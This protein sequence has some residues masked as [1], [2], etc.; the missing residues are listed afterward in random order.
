MSRGK[1][2]GAER[3]VR[4]LWKAVGWWTM[5]ILRGWVIAV[6]AIVRTDVGRRA[7]ALRLT[8]SDR[9]SGVVVD[10]A[11]CL[12]AVLATRTRGEVGEQIWLDC[13]VTCQGLA[14]VET[15]LIVHGISLYHG[16][17]RKYKPAF[18]RKNSSKVLLH[19]NCKYFPRSS[20]GNFKSSALCDRLRAHLTSNVNLYTAALRPTPSTPFTSKVHTAGP[21][22]STAGVC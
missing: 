13:R 12:A 16:Y 20:T 1:R 19:P 6:V 9:S 7:S 14:F 2:E 18:N 22:I 4:G 11:S 15:W 21:C 5:P 3:E 17:A 8:A 10:I